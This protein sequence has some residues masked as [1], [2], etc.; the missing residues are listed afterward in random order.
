MPPRF[1]SFFIDT[2]GVHLARRLF[3]GSSFP[4]GEAVC[5]PH[6]ALFSFFFLLDDGAACNPH[7]ALFIPLIIGGSLMAGAVYNLHAAP[8]FNCIYPPFSGGF[9][10]VSLATAG[11]AGTLHAAPF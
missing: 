5:I 10:P 4:N 7:A 9:F 8:L 11:T 2:G 3:F 6:T 1:L